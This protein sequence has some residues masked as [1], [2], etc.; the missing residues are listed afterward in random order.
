MTK[1]EP[2]SRTFKLDNETK[3]T[4]HYTEGAEATDC[5]QMH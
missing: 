5:L 1:S 3:N 2:F 4:V